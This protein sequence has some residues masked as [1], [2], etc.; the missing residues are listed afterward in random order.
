M[1][2]GVSIFFS[3][4]FAFSSASFVNNTLSSFGIFVWRLY[5]ECFGRIRRVGR[6][7]VRVGGAWRS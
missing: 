1:S 6:K 2:D 7:M 5:G 3:L 4:S